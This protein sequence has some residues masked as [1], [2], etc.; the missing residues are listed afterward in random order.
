MSDDLKIVVKT[1]VGM[2]ILGGIFMAIYSY[3]LNSQTHSLNVKG[4]IDVKYST[5]NDYSKVDEALEYICV[6]M[7]NKVTEQELAEIILDY[8]LWFNC[9]ACNNK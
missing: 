6:K 5:E 4:L 3:T 1:V 8:H 7:D 2:I 9:S